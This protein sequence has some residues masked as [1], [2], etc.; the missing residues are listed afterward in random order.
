MEGF[1]RGEVV[2]LN[3]PFS[4]LTQSK[5]R[6]AFIIKV[7]KGG[8]LI[9]CQI[10]GTSQ[11]KSAEIPIK[12]EDFE[13]ENLKVESYLRMDKV[14]SVEKSLI[15]YKIGPLKKEKIEEILEKVCSFLKN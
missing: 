7:P 3:F 4:N 2:V 10:T 11:E 12:R 5:R 1:V 15:K 13:K 6:P 9:V 14:F 8:D